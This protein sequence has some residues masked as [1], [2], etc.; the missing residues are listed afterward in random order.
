MVKSLYNKENQIEK[1]LIDEQRVK[2]TL[3]NKYLF[4]WVSAKKMDLL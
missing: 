3:I 1:P 2:S 4:D